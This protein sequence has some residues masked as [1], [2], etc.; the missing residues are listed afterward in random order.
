MKYKREIFGVQSYLVL[1]HHQ[2]E[3]SGRFT[4]GG[5]LLLCF[6]PSS[7]TDEVEVFFGET[8]CLSEEDNWQAGQEGLQSSKR[9]TQN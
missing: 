5:F 8:V 4:G 3:V 7:V 6:Y 9:V 1:L 2:R